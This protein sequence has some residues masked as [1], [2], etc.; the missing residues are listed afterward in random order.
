[1]NIAYIVNARIPTE[2]AHGFQIMKVCEALAALGHAVELVVPARA[3]AITLDAFSYYGLSSDFP[4]RKL[5][6][7]DRGF[8]IQ[9]SSF[10]A[11]LLLLKLSR[12]TI[13][14]TRDPEI[15]F[16]FIHRGHRVFYYAHNWPQSKIGLFKFM[17][18]GVTG[19]I[20]NSK[21]TE[22][23]FKAEG[24]SNTIAVPN[25]VDLKEF[26]ALGDKAMLRARLSIPTDK[27]IAMYVGHLYEWK[28]ID[29]VIA[30]AEVLNDDQR[31]MFW[32]IGGTDADIVKYRG[33]VIEKGLTN[34][35]ILGHKNHSEISSFLS[36]AD[37]LLL[38]NIPS[39]TESEHYTSPIKM[40]EYM[41]SGTPIIASDMPSMR[42]VLN[43]D[44]ST[45]IPA[46][47]AHALADAIA[48]ISANP[49][50]LIE[51]ATRAKVEARTYSWDSL[52]HKIVSFIAV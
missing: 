42:E 51:K 11:S 20:C 35:S 44:N 13:I 34:I 3:N 31:I 4:I 15:A 36:A 38:P 10:L 41:A 12:N 48:R 45:L 23:E 6:V 7:V 16:L 1:M 40:F 46:R 50:Q 29:V 37:M 21:G 33:I 9:S 5:R 32:I 47:D 30:A 8:R 25:A 2:K 39:S 24:F 49:E 52:A 43:D 27:K 22:A 28:G 17:L 19:V 14:M 26:D 18:K